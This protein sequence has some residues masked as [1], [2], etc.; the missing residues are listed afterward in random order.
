MPL[1]I[2]SRIASSLVFLTVIVAGPLHQG[3]GRTD[4]PQVPAD[5]Q[6]QVAKL[7]AQLGHENFRV[8]LNAQA[9]LEKIGL[10]AYEQLRE[11]V[12]HN[13]IQIARSAEYLLKSQ[14]VV[15]WLESDS[16][17]VRTRLQDYSSLNNVERQT[18]LL[19]LASIGTDDALLALCRVAKFESSE[20]CSRAAAIGL[21]SKLSKLEG[22]RQDSLLQAVLI[23]IGRANRPATIWLQSF[24][25]QTLNLEV[26]SLDVWKDYV[27]K[28]NLELSRMSRA[29]FKA[30]I[31]STNF[32]DEQK[33]QVLQFYE[34]MIAWIM[35]KQGR[36]AALD[37]AR[38]SLVLVSK[39]L[40]AVREYSTW[41]LSIE[42]PE[43]VVELLDSSKPYLNSDDQQLHYLLA[44]AHRKLNDEAKATE[45]ATRAR[46]IPKDNIAKLG[47]LARGS[48]N[49]IQA[50]QRLMQAMM[51]DERG[52]FDWEEGEL[53]EAMALSQV[54]GSD[55]DARY[56]LAELYREGKQYTKAVEVMAVVADSKPPDRNLPLA[57]FDYSTMLASYHWYQALDCQQS[58]KQDEAMAALRKACELNSKSQKANPDIIINL[59][60]L[61]KTPEDRAFFREHFNK[62]VEQYR[63]QVTEEETRLV[64]A[65]GSLRNTQRLAESCNQLAWLLANCDTNI[66]EAIYLSQRSLEFDPEV[67]TYLDTLARCF[68]AAG[69]FEEAVRYQTKA[70]KGAPHNRSMKSQLAEFQTA[71]EKRQAQQSQ[72]ENGK[73]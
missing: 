20:W 55:Y 52:M 40:H 45:V 47:Q 46:R 8:R 61:A 35:H 32:M 51:L 11:A 29:S 63:Q 58:G 1:R 69:R 62:L 3:L 9:E 39:N 49:A 31:K 6:T 71:L 7:I 30:P 17:E 42:L 24:S 15:W 13:D 37:V 21:L 59:H 72:D 68:F 16:H 22:Q 5:T 14:N 27:D 33:L 67:H 26:F 65:T 2:T 44:E 57:D 50:N 66:E 28:L 10:A 56:L 34:W 12:V 54:S 41:A 4:N 36:E 43:L 73:Q 25:N 53:L 38:P 23:T 18:R 19:E 48:A 64:E 60:R 70:L